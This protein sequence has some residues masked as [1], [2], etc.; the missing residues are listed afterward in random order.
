MCM[1][2]KFIKAG[3][4]RTLCVLLSTLL[5]IGTG[6]TDV[7]HALAE[8]AYTGLAVE[9]RTQSD[10]AEKLKSVWELDY[11]AEYAKEPATSVPYEAGK[12]TQEKQEN[13]LALINAIRY[14]AGLS[15]NVNQNESY[16]TCA[17]AAALV[18]CVN[19]SLSHYPTCP[20]DMDTELCETAKLGAGKSNLSW[21]TTNLRKMVMMFMDDSG[22][23]TLGHRRWIL[24]PMLQNVGFGMVGGYGAMHAVDNFSSENAKAV[25]GVAWPAQNM[26]LELWDDGNA[27]SVSFGRSLDAENIDV[28][29]SKNNGQQSWNLTGAAGD[30]SLSISNQN[31]GQPG[32]VIFTPNS[33]SY[34]DGDI[35]HI[36]IKE[37]DEIIAD[38]DVNFFSVYEKNNLASDFSS[39]DK[40]TDYYYDDDY[41]YDDDA[42]LKSEVI[43]E[44]KMQKVSNLKLV[45]QIDDYYG[46]LDL[47]FEWMQP[48][49]HKTE[50]FYY[51][52]NGKYY[53]YTAGDDCSESDDRIF[54]NLNSAYD[55]EVKR[56]RGYTLSVQPEYRVN[57]TNV[58]GETVELKFATKPNKV[59]GVNVKTTSHKIKVSWNKKVGSGYQVQIASNSKFTKNKKTYKIASSK[60]LSKT[61]S[62]LKSGQKYYVR[63]RAYKAYGNTAY[64]KWSKTKTIT[65]K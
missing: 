39:N 52:L 50:I 58:M 15:S 32:C 27:W 65:C 3:K 12:L 51:Y 47:N 40:S 2:G 41:N 60:T 59:T 38:Y 46:Y 49:K 23:S 45:K 37:A 5:L 16:V 62:G 9:Y 54:M 20:E 30:G 64:G 21:G 48:E 42:G 22:T 44:M 11:D 57:H 53:G 29:I 35:Y 8:V 17:Q 28:E 18:N 34:K 26:P 7:T 19:K 61:I 43:S 56:G 31:Y 13:A 36:T 24:Y 63:I 6:T 1:K 55:K 25:P 10:V 14:I 33:A 4:K